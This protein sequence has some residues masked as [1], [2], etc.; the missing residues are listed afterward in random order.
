MPKHSLQR[1]GV[2]WFRDH[3]LSGQP[4]FCCQAVTAGRLG[5]VCRNP[6]A[7]LGQPSSGGYDGFG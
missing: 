3:R 7:Q 2:K 5:G 1:L 6:Q 4:G